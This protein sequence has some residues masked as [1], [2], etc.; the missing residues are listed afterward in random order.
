[1]ATNLDQA[2]VELAQ[3]AGL[4][5]RVAADHLSKHGFLLTALGAT[6]NVGWWN[7]TRYTTHV[8]QT[9]DP[10]FIEEMSMNWLMSDHKKSKFVGVVMDG[11]ITVEGNKT[12]AL[13]LRSR[14]VNS[15]TRM[16]AYQPYKRAIE[17]SWSGHTIVDFPAELAVS[18]EARDEA[19]AI[20]LEAM[21]GKAS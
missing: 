18:A 15:S 4:Q 21:F 16:M 7:G 2:L 8:L 17:D 10:Q 1:M 13:I 12:E 19:L 11:W 6:M 3:F 20:M 14:K 5:L 9:D